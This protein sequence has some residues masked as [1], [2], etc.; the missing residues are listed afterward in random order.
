MTAA[1]AVYTT[2]PLR[3][4]TG[5]TAATVV[6]AVSAT[7]TGL[8]VAPLAVLGVLVL[9]LVFGHDRGR[10]SVDR[11]FESLVALGS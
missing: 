10:P 9:A 11:T 1:T 4:S 2:P 6:V 8:A 7:L 3:A 5:K